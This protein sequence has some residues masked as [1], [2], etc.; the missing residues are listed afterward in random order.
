MT[1]SIA[2][3]SLTGDE[4]DVADAAALQRGVL[5]QR[6]LLGELREQAD[7]SGHDVVEVDGIA[8]EALDGLALGGAHRLDVGDLIHEQSVAAIG[9]TRPALVCGWVM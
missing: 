3:V 4:L 1:T 2:R 8:E 6:Y 7:R 5:H 9:G